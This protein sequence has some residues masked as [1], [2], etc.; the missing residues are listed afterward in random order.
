M[1]VFQNTIIQMYS[2][3]LCTVDISARNTIGLALP[4]DYIYSKCDRVICL[5]SEILINY[6]QI[7][8]FKLF[9]SASV[10]K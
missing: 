1:W 7:N 5:K 6:V 3:H 10:I 4:I 2:L 9:I 8:D